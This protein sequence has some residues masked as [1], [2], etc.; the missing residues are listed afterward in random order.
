MI[1]KT[2]YQWVARGL[3][4][5]HKQI[6]LAQLTFRLMQKNPAILMGTYTVK[7]MNFL[8]N[9][10]P[11][12]DTP[13]AL[14]EWLPNTAWFS[15]QRLI[16]IEGFENFSSN[17]EKEAPG[18]FRDWYNEIT[19]EA[20]KVPLEWKKLE[21]MPF[22]KLLVVRCLRPDRITAAMD[23]FIRITLPNGSEYVDMDQTASF[24]QILQSSY[25]DSTTTTPIFFI[26]S[27]GANPVAFVE[28]LCRK[29]DKVPAKHLHTISL[30][31]GQDI[32]A[33][34]KLE[35]GHKEGHWVMLQNIHLMPKWL[36]ELEK[37]LDGFASEGSHSDFRVFLSSDP[38]DGIPIGLLEKSIKL[39]N[40]P[41]QGLKPNMKRAFSSFPKE[42][43]EEKDPKIKTI[44]FGLCYFHTVMMERRK[45]G[46]KGWNMHYPFSMGDLRDSSI[47]LKN[48]ME[49]NQSS[50]KLPW[51][52]L[53]YIFGEIM[54]GGHIVDNWDRRFCSAFLD[55]LMQDSLL[56]EAEL[57]PF[58]EGK[59]VTFKCP[60]AMPYEKYIE[61]IENGPGDTPLAFGMHPNAE[62][63]YR[64]TQCIV[65]FRTLQELAPKETGAGEDGGGGQTLQDKI[66]EFMHRV[67][68][69]VQLDQNKIN[70][71]DVLSK[72]NEDKDPYQNVFLQECELM[73]VLI[74]E[75]LKSL[76]EIELS[77]KGELTMTPKMEALMDSIALNQ[78]PGPWAKY[79]FPSTRPLGTWLD[80]LK[81]RLE[82]LNIW[83]E[84]PMNIPK[85]VFLNRLFNPQSFLTAIKQ[86]YSRKNK[87]ELNRLVIQT[88]FMKYMYYQPELP[89]CK[90]G[91]YVFGCQV[92]GA[93][94]D[95]GLGNLEESFPKKQ[96]SV[97]PVVNCRAAMLAADGKEEKNVY[98]CPVYK[99]ETR[100]STY[101]FTAQMKTKLPPQK[102]I[103]A[104][105]AMILD[106]EGV[107]DA[108]SL[109]KDP[110]AI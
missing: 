99:T 78:I 44:L 30:G 83:K 16:E 4:E 7:E 13:N 63:D 60:Q 23:N 70:I 36:L 11:K 45:F 64:T 37:K 29:N 98:Q 65:L 54:Y 26:L 1:R 35:I 40:E 32:V 50:G 104:G 21:Q 81:H 47:V 2:I 8:L 27:P 76:Q 73:N 71:E 68:D 10:P 93:R 42:E 90:D 49:T 96:F 41:P 109:G 69:E 58:I 43:I 48:Y 20:E 110:T 3:F 22:Q 55:N 97:V 18:R 17:M 102:W 46:S 38:S 66:Q 67:S 72:L 88:D 52:D 84:D 95:Q 87:A 75:I 91:A 101:V 39:T 53:K 56:D 19:P 12:T 24:I 89:P 74:H 105:V 33:M 107:S 34:N 92:E 51:D 79:A 82:Q 14:K 25:E 15:V 86:V 31:Q 108:Y 85:V 80:N 100:G 62:I 94:W 6:F 28:D 103:L 77:F 5:K 61:H 59:N 9:C 106:V 57:F